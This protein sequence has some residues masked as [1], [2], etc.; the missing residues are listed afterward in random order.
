MSY[1]TID[2]FQSVRLRGNSQQTDT[3]NLVYAPPTHRVTTIGGTPA[4]TTQRSFRGLAIGAFEMHNRSGSAGVHGLGV[5]IPND[6]WI[7]GLWTTG[8]GFEDDTV[9]AQDTGASDF[10]LE[11]VAQANAGFIIASRVQ[12]NAVSINVGTASVGGSPVR[13]IRFTNSVGDGWTDLTGSSTTMFI[14][15]G[16]SAHYATGEQLLVFAPPLGWGRV[17]TGGLSSIPAGYY[18]LNVRST[19]QVGTTAGVATAIEIARL[20]FLTENILDNGVLSRDAT[21]PLVMEPEGDA[22]VALFGTAADGNRIT[23]QVKTH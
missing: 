8:N 18:A 12:F 19:T 4:T 7:A 13:A 16:A 15:D 17:A 22:L 5:R 21:F 6:Q 10:P 2:V 20:Y 14:H 9:D 1:N 23:V 3:A 11:V